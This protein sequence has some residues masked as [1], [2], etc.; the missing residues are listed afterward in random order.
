MIEKSTVWYNEL[1]HV[2]KVDSLDSLN[3][4]DDIIAFYH[5]SRE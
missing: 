4:V 3:A 2:K 5:T 1:D